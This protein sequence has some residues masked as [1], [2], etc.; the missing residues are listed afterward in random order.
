MDEL[1]EVFE[2]EGKDENTWSK[3]MSEV[4]KNNDNT[5]NLK[6]FLDA[7]MIM[8]SKKAEGGPGPMCI[9]E[10]KNGDEEEEEEAED[11]AK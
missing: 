4:D 11:E 10:E 9:K 1:K 7:T 8:A 3:I 6:E 5:I 2:G